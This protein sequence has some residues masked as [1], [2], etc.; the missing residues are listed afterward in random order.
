MSTLYVVEPGAQIEKEYHRLLVT[1]ADEVL[2][3]VPIQQVTQVVMV[4]T[5]GATTPA[6]HAL[7]ENEIP[8]YF[9]KRSGELMGR[10][11]PSTN[12]NLPLR[13]AQYQRENEESFR[14][15]V[16][17]AIVS[18]KLHNQRVLALRILRRG[19][20]SP[21]VAMEEL[22]AAA[23]NIH[24]DTDLDSL[25]GFEGSGA[26][27]YFLIF[28]R[29]FDV[30]WNFN[31]RNRRPPK[32]PINALLSLGYTFLTHALTTAI[33]IVGMDPYLGIFHVEKYGRPALALD[34]LEEF[35]APVVDSL[36]M[37][38]VNRRIIQ[39]DDFYPDS[40]DTAGVRLTDHG[41]HIFVRQFSDRLESEIHIRG[42]KKAMSYRKVF[43]I[44]ARRLSRVILGEEEIYHPFLAR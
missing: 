5:V 35:R 38:L 18:A 19:V 34:L 42:V 30:S 29:A 12:A 17:G 41:M 28:Q 40:S 15:K 1:K 20:N 14:R 24:L 2:L 37:G 23:E 8:L 10:L 39:K 44:Q 43:E 21:V 3:R 6:L 25:L 22:R 4:G 16:A 26:R 11:V 36:V 31:D 13:K 27:A 32:D 33:E 9:V 7:L